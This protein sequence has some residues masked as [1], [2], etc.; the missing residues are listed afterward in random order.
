MPKIVITGGAG[1]IGGSAAFFLKEKGYTPIVLDNFS[2]S[3]RFKNSPFNIYEVDLCDFLKTERV[4]KELGDI[5]AV[6]HFAAKALVFESFEKVDEYLANNILATLNVAKLALKYETKF[7]IHSSSCSVYGL[8]SEI[9]IKESAALDPI[10]PYGESKFISE[11]ILAQLSKNKG[12][13]VGNLR[14]FNPAGS[15]FCGAW[16]EKHKPETHL[17]PNIVEAAIKNKKFSI[18]GKDYPTKDGTAIRDLIHIEDLIEAHLK[19]LKLL[20]SEKFK[21]VSL[22]IG[23]GEG[24]SVKE[25]LEEARKSLNIDIQAEFLERRPLEPHCLIAD[26]SFSEKILGWRPKRA[27]K[28]MILSHYNFRINLEKQKE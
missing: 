2:T 9:P 1:Y 24:F 3:E 12:L 15:I 18:F 25:V 14:Y 7:F 13:R 20:E 23:R 21:Y 16:G 8:P 11:R 26:T 22:N 19:T 5:Y 27:L 6:F 10:S 4:W 28:D 17:I